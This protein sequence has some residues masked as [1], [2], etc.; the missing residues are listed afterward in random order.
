M[1]LHIL[2]CLS[3]LGSTML[4][5]QPSP[6]FSSTVGITFSVGSSVIFPTPSAPYLADYKHFHSLT[7][8]PVDL[9]HM[10]PIFHYLCLFACFLSVTRVDIMLFMFPPI[11]RI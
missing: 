9:H 1:A 6:F 10:L 11:P 4:V 7:A 2:S 8:F 3:G 5:C